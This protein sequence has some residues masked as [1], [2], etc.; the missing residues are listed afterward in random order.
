LS[1][2][3]SSYEARLKFLEDFRKDQSKD[4]KDREFSTKRIN[5]YFTDVI[6]GFSLENQN[7]DRL[8]ELL[9]KFAENSALKLK[10]TNEMRK[11]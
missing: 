1:F 7:L 10:I 11:L 9:E 2:E 8:N 4:P 6:Y 5:E 3:L